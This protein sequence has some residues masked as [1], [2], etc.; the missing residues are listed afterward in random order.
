MRIAAKDRTAWKWL[1][2][3]NMQSNGANAA[4]LPVFRTEAVIEDRQA[5]EK[6]AS[7]E[8]PF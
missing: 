8:S 5:S 1:I 6:D 7:S 3:R 2:G 4:V